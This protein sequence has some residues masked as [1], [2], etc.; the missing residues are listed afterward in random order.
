MSTVLPHQLDERYEQQEGNYSVV[1]GEGT[2]STP[3]F[4]VCSSEAKEIASG[5]YC[6]ILKQYLLAN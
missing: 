3:A 1:S 5:K 2:Y 6:E 4:A